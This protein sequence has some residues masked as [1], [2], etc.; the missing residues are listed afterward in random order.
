MVDIFKVKSQ[1]GY[2]DVVSTLEA[3]RRTIQWYLEHPL[4]RGGDM[5]QRLLDPFDYDAEDRWVSIAK[6][7][8]QQDDGGR[9][10]QAR[11]ERASISASQ[12]AGLHARPSQSLSRGR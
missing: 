12:G 5:E 11:T 1:L 4:E 10:P 7:Y 2:R 9:S 6:E 3:V 8:Y